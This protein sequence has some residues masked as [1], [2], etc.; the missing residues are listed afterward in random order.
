MWTGAPD[1]ES[2]AAVATGASVSDAAAVDADVDDVDDAGFVVELFEQA[3]RNKDKTIITDK[4]NPS[5]LL[6]IISCPPISA[7]L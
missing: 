3:E 4:M 7:K 2:G 5:L 1:P 6:V